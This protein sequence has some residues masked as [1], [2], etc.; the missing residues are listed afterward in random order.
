METRNIKLTLETATR[1]YNGSD[2]ELKQLALQ[3]YP[4]LGKKELPKTW[5]ELE[6]K[7]G[8]CTDIDSIIHGGLQSSNIRHKRFDKNMFAT[9]EQAEASLA[10]AQLSQLKK[11]YNGDWVADWENDEQEKYCI[12]FFDNEVD[13]DTWLNTN[14]FLSF[15][16]KETR[17]LFLENFR[18]LIE[19]AKPLMS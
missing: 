16:D 1:W 9:Q 12:M 4:E 3:T 6:I 11:V 18:D 14:Y 5:E 7:R 10:L 19:K 17:D 2:E 15:K 8:Y 13:T